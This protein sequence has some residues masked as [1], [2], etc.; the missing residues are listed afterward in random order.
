VS[1]LR[2]PSHFPPQ[3]RWGKFFIGV[4][5]L[6][7]DLSFFK[8]LKEQQ[9]IRSSEAVSAWGGGDKQKLAQAISSVLARQLG[10]KSEVFLPEDSVAVAFH[11]PRFDFNDPES[12]FEEVVEELR[13]E[14]GISMPESFWAKQTER[15][16]GELVND[17]LANRDG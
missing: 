4:R 9:A 6:G 13:A 1:A 10:W 17:L 7:P 16:L 2:F 8:Q 12:A 3:D 14:F 5:W 15:T 11:G